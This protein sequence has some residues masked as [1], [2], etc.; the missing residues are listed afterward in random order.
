MR[1]I[2]I[3]I[4]LIL[5]FSNVG[6]IFAEGENV[7]SYKFQED[8]NI[9]GVVGSTEK[10]FEVKENW[11]V[12]DVKFNLV[13]TKSELLDVDISTLTVFVN[14]QPV[15]SMRLDGNKEYKKQVLIDIPKDLIKPGYNSV[16]IKAYKTIS[17]EI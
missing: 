15:N 4:S 8:I 13:F 17:D 14:G 3:I 1:V 6:I 9:S 5:T 11:D 16:S 12:Q 10:F 2:T 7:K